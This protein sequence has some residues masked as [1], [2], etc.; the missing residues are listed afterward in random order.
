MIVNHTSTVFLSKSKNQ[1]FDQNRD[2]DPPPQ[3]GPNLRLSI[4]GRALKFWGVIY[5]PIW[6]LNQ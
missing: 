2:F 6:A 5:Y 1:V 4:I 3:R